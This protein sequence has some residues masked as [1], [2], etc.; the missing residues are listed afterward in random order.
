MA[1]H[2]HEPARA[3]FARLVLHIAIEEAESLK[4]RRNVLRSIKGRLRHEFN[5]SIVEVE[6]GHG[7]QSGLLVAAAVSGD[8]QYLAGQMESLLAAL[9]RQF[10]GRLAD[11][12]LQIEDL[13]LG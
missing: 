7:P 13:P 5:I 11:Q 12:E 6:T 4:D 2:S 1:N 3:C 9:E 10:P 8:R